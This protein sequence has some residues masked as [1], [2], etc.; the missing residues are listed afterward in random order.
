MGQAYASDFL[1]RLSPTAGTG[2]PL[3]RSPPEWN[4]VLYT[5]QSS[6]CMWPHCTVKTTRLGALSRLPSCCTTSQRLPFRLTKPRLHLSKL[7]IVA[8]TYRVL[9]ICQT[10]PQALYVHY[11]PSNPR[12][13]PDRV[14]FLALF[15]RWGKEAQKE[16]S[17]DQWRSQKVQSKSKGHDPNRGIHAL[18]STSPVHTPNKPW[19]HSWLLSA[20][21]IYLENTDL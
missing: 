16:R 11:Y 13:K 14:L 20:A 6:A 5:Q 15:Y 19:G 2:P 17:S 3:L 21:P 12:E 4:T 1:C 7:L 8:N 10:L 18:E 9:P